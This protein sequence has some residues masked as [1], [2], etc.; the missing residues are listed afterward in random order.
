MGLE[1]L[2]S[3]DA[4]CQ[5]G[6]TGTPTAKSEWLASSIVPFPPVLTEKDREDK[7]LT[8]RQSSRA[9]FPRH[10]RDTRCVSAPRA[11]LPLAGRYRAYVSVIATVVFS[12]AADCRHRVIAHVFAVQGTPRTH[13]VAGK[14]N[15]RDLVSWQ[16]VELFLAGQVR[17]NSGANR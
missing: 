9:V 13:C 7:R 6:S 14:R 8:R 10:R 16:Q 1:V 15:S 11:P 2:V 12:R 5:P 17:A 4:F 3:C